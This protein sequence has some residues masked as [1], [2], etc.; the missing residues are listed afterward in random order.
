MDERPGHHVIVTFL[1]QLF[2]RRFQ[3]AA[4]FGAVG[5]V[6]CHATV[7]L[8][9][10]VKF[11]L[12]GRVI[13]AISTQGRRLLNEEVSVLGSM[14]A[15]AIGAPAARSSLV[16]D[17]L[18]HDVIMTLHTEVLGRLHQK[19]F[20]QGAVRVMTDQAAVRFAIDAGGKSR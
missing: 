13:M 19:F 16:E 2:G 12:F 14:G 4:V 6:T 17:L 15:V 9:D 8:D 11:A 10:G 1:A 7:I 20:V 5:I 18:G 3:Q